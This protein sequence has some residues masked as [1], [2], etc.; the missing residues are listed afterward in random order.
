M[1]SIVVIVRPAASG[2]STRHDGTTRPF[3]ITEQAPQS[4]V[5]QPSFVPVSPRVSRSEVRSVASASARNSTG[6]PL[7][8]A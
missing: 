4:P 1:P 5:A 6:S 8:L 3:M 7:M 2:A